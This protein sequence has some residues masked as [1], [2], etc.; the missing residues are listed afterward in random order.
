MYGTYAYR[1]QILGQVFSLRQHLKFITSGA[2]NSITQFFRKCGLMLSG[3]TTFLDAL[4]LAWI[5]KVCRCVF[6]KCLWGGSAVSGS[7]IYSLHTEL[8]SQEFRLWTDV[9]HNC[10]QHLGEEEWCLALN[11]LFFLWLETTIVWT[12]YW[13]LSCGSGCP[14]PSGWLLI[15]IFHMILGAKKL[16]LQGCCL[17]FL[18]VLYFASNASLYLELNHDRSVLHKSD[19]VMYILIL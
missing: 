19:E 12:Q 3:P 9:I 11:G 1:F 10:Y 18:H 2:A 16:W 15:G 17:N 4:L 13:F 8:L 5:C 7:S 6:V 14:F